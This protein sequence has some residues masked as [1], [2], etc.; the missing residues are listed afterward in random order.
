MNCDPAPARI[1]LV[2]DDP[3]VRDL[4]SKRLARWGYEVVCAPE[5]ATA[6]ALLAQAPVDAVVSDIDMPG[7]T[8]LLF[9]S[10]LAEL[11]PGLPVILITGKPTVESA[12]SAVALGVRAYLLKP[13]AAEQLRS[14][15]AA[16]VVAR[17]LY[18]AVSS[19]GRG[20]AADSPR[21]ED[22]ALLAAA[23]ARHGA[24]LSAA[25]ETE[26]LALT[27]SQNLELDRLLAAL[28]EAVAVIARTKGAFKSQDLALLRRRLEAELAR[29]GPPA[30]G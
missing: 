21:A 14:A 20:L 1:L 6:L 9:V 7:N 5:A 30:A 10:R 15:V 3:V 13:Y 8:D 26:P 17:R 12:V 11:A 25:A 24:A 22:L 16:A 19:L 18:A 4:E 27:V 23:A 2:D 28:R 29:F